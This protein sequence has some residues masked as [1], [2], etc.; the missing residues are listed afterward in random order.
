MRIDLPIPV[1]RGS[2]VIKR[3]LI[4]VVLVLVSFASGWFLS[5]GR[6]DEEF[7]TTRMMYLRDQSNSIGT[8]PAG[9]RVFAEGYIAPDVGF[10]GCIPVSA[11]HCE[12]LNS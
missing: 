4:S 11:T 2:T 8:L 12:L 5:P 9:T 6:N 3:L 7:E 10:V 1:T